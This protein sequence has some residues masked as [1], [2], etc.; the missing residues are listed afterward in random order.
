[1][2]TPILPFFPQTRALQRWYLCMVTA[3]EGKCGQN[4]TD[5]TFINAAYDMMRVYERNL[6]ECS[7]VKKYSS[8]LQITSN[9]SVMLVLLLV[10]ALLKKPVNDYSVFT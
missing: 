1:M 2:F 3:L 4:K 8:S 6:P 5:T 10:C 9:Y 7:G